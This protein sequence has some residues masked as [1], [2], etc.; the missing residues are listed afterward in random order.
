MAYGFYGSAD[1]LDRFAAQGH[2]SSPYSVYSA[3]PQRASMASAAPPEYGSPGTFA[4]RRAI[5]PPGGHSSISLGDASGGYGYE[6][7]QP[8]SSYS[9]QPA[10]GSIL[11]SYG[12][13]QG[14]AYS[15]GAG[16]SVSAAGY[17][18][19]GGGNDLSSQLNIPGLRR[20]PSAG[21]RAMSQPT[22]YGMSSYGSG[23]GYGAGSSSYAAPS[24]YNSYSTQ[25]GAGGASSSAYSS[26]SAGYSS[27][28]SP[29]SNASSYS[30]GYGSSPAGGSYGA[31]GYGASAYGAGGGADYGQAQGYGGGYGGGYGASSPKGAYGSATNLP[32]PAHQAAFVPG[33]KGQ[34]GGKVITQPPGGKTSINLFG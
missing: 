10:G 13:G 22:G 4:G 12:S 32:T 23:S 17:S 11:Q 7:S 24:S 33:Q 27:Y 16:Y 34:F 29:Y 8:Y 14:S 26:P 30:N 25:Y 20:P 19:Y 3:Y 21:R 28:S 9:A 6:R 15:A 31:S 18:A 2:Y 1:A 5:Q